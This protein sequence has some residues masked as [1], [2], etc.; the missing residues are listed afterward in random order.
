MTKSKRTTNT[1][2]DFDALLPHIGEMGRYQLGLY[3]LMC[4]PATLPAAFLAFNQVFISASPDHW[5]RVSA[6]EEVGNL[7]KSHIR[8]LSIPRR[9]LG[10]GRL[11]MYERCL[12]Y[13]VNFTEVFETNGNEWPK[14]ADPA[15]PVADCQE[16]WTFDQREY[17]DTMVTEVSLVPCLFTSNFQK[18]PV[19]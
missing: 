8:R 19:Y 11:G 2:V 15:W 1:I 17:Q 18:K 13:D 14:R 3:L 6:L 10:N 9:D 7:S 12:R 4:I 16:G 5:C